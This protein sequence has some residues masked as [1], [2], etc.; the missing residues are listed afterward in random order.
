MQKRVGM[1]TCPCGTKESYERCCAPYHRGE[2]YPE[3]AEKLMRSRYV[4]FTR[5]DW[6]YLARTQ[7]QPF[8]RPEPNPEWEGL[9]ILAVTEGGEHDPTGWVEFQ[10]RFRLESRQTHHERSLFIRRGQR[11]L[12]DRGEPGRRQNPKVGRNEPCPCGSG[13]KYK[14]C[15][16]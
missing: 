14:R 7:T 9:T 6:D 3:T 5:Q 15:C 1:T 12:Y 8:T 10:A 13:K 11:W 16:A 2:A 4:A